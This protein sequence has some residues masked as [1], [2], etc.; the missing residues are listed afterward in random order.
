MAVVSLLLLC[1]VV[2]LL[3]NVIG[4]QPAEADLGRQRA[5][6]GRKN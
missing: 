2:L 4:P 6:S 1:M 3:V 5:R